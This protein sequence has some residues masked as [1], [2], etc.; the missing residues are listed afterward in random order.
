[1]NVVF[2][3]SNLVNN[4]T[5]QHRVVLQCCHLSRQNPCSSGTLRTVTD[6]CDSTWGSQSIR[7]SVSDTHRC[8]EVSYLWSR[9]AWIVTWIRDVREQI[10]RTRSL[11]F[12]WLYSRGASISADNRYR[13][14]DNRH[15]PI[16]GRSADYVLV[17]NTTKN[18]FNCSSLWWQ[19][20]N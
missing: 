15:R 12:Q 6:D 2:S 19:W 3:N 1:M 20:G 11:P 8:F 17:S 5:E 13:P 18:A 10:F 14:F 16:I 4:W 9:D 7:I